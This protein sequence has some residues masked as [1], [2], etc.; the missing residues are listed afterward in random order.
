MSEKTFVTTRSTPVK[1][2][3]CVLLSSILLPAMASMGAA[4]E[5]SPEM[6]DQ[7]ARVAARRREHRD[8]RAVSRTS[9]RAADAIRLREAREHQARMAPVLAAREAAW[10]R[11]VIEAQRLRVE[12]A[13]MIA[14]FRQAQATARL[15]DAVAYDAWASAGRRYRWP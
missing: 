10:R 13:E 8:R 4:D 11:D 7:V 12:Q 2:V 6:T 3:E 5:P 1:F 15:A 9:R 14:R